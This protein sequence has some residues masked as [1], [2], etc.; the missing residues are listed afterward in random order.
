MQKPASQ[1]SFTCMA[2]KNRKGN[3]NNPESTVNV[4]WP[5]DRAPTQLPHGASFM[6]EKKA[7]PVSGRDPKTKK[8]SNFGIQG[9]SQREAA[10]FL[11]SL[12]RFFSPHNFL[13]ASS[14][15]SKDLALHLSHLRG[16]AQTPHWR[17]TTRGQR[18]HC[19]SCQRCR[20]SNLRTKKAWKSRLRI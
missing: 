1:L 19:G 18:P 15:H 8:I 16:G 14:D 6:T 4:V 5:T 17:L 10:N 9:H 11:S 12:Y 13:H 20:C 2:E 7:S 3:A